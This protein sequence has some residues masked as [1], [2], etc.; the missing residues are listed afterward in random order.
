MLSVMHSI[1]T[2]KTAISKLQKLKHLEHKSGSVDRMGAAP[3]QKMSDNIFAIPDVLLCVMGHINNFKYLDNFKL[4]CKATNVS[5]EEIH[6]RVKIRFRPVDDMISAYREKVATRK[7]SP[8]RPSYS[9]QTD[10]NGTIYGYNINVIDGIVWDF[11][12]H[13]YE[14]VICRWAKSVGVG[15]CIYYQSSVVEFK[16]NS[17]LRVTGIEHNSDTVMAVVRYLSRYVT[18]TDYATFVATK[19]HYPKLVMITNYPHEQHSDTIIDGSM[20]SGGVVE[21]TI[22][23]NVLLSCRGFGTIDASPK[24]VRFATSVQGINRLLRYPNLVVAVINIYSNM[25]EDTMKYI[26]SV[27]ADTNVQAVRFRPMHR[28]GCAVKVNTPSGWECKDGYYVKNF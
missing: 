7:R 3:P 28:Y 16:K 23:D 22:P 19:I 17:V 27:V 4:L 12:T 9:I 18:K 15:Q 14:I 20:S 24:V 21:P 11:E 10:E 6:E 25:E 2:Y 1:L 13:D 5:A 8:R 26:F